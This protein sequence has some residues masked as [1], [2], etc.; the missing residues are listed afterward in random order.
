M[1]P[2]DF[3]QPLGHGIFRI[4]IGFQRAGCAAA[5]LLVHDGRGCFIDAGTT[6]SVPR[7]LAA[8]DAAGLAREAID[9]VILTHV[10]LDHAGGTGAL[11]ASLP[12]ARLLVH[13]RGARHMIDPTQLWEGALGVFGPDELA[14]SY[15]SVAAVPAARVEATADG[16]RISVGGREL[17]LFDSPGHA[18]HHQ[19]IWDETSGGCFAG[20]TFGL[21]Y[22][23]FD[24][25]RGPW[26]MPSTPPVQFDPEALR[27]SI[28]RIMALAPRSIYLAHFGAVTDIP[29][30]AADLLAGVD[31]HAAIA[32]A[33]RSD[34][35]PDVAAI[36]RDLFEWHAGSLAN[37][38][39][40]LDRSRIAE[41]IAFD[42]HLNACG[43]AGY[44][45]QAASNRPRHPQ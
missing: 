40:T 2:P 36:E 20:D 38:G 27:R 1:T 4:D 12:N 3:L 17:M 10:H 30:L 32:I 45:A 16:T 13:A 37:H 7:L 15:G 31:R 19:C 18:R 28:D 14:R 34:Q 21:S 43:I 22:R 8:V 5:Y 24:T 41:L 42:I 39:C 11:M 23:E 26:I 29:R 33:A 25:P 9:W 6:P 35:P 44:A